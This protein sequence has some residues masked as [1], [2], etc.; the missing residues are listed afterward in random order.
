MLESS[1]LNVFD[2][3]G[4]RY[5]LG[6]EKDLEQVRRSPFT[7]AKWALDKAVKLFQEN[8]RNIKA[9]SPMQDGDDENSDPMGMSNAVLSRAYVCLEQKNYKAALHNAEWVLKLASTS[10][11]EKMDSIRRSLV[12]RQ[13]AT[14]RMYASEA[15]CVLGKKT[16]SLQHLVG[17]GKE[18]AFERL[19]SDLAGV[20]MASASKNAEGKARLAKAQASVRC[21]ASIAS[22]DLGNLAAAKQLAMSARAMEDAFY[23]SSSSRLGGK[24]REGSLARRALVYCNLREKQVQQQQV[25]GGMVLNTN[26]T[27]I[28]SASASGNSGLTFTLLRSAR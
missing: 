15:A 24:D 26:P 22:C 2:P 7:R 11:L 4:L 10:D 28:A 25:R 1:T 23:H 12:K 16:K 19:A 6:S 14:A 18:D 13:L 8:Q 9:G 20:T 17:D 21:S 27:G 5:G 3:K